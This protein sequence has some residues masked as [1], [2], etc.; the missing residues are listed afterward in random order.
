MVHCRYKKHLFITKLRLC[1]FFSSSVLLVGT[2]TVPEDKFENKNI[3]LLL[4]HWYLSFLFL[5][6]FL[7]FPGRLGAKFLNQSFDGFLVS[8]Q[9]LKLVL[10]K[11]VVFQFAHD[12]VH[13][14]FIFID[15]LPERV[16]IIFRA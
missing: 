9:L 1:E 13:L 10:D 6:Y 2:P 3:S 16:G 7:V 5:G 12:G 11:L 8:F 14:I 4:V 15:H